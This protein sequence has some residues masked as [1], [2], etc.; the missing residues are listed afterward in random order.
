M[1]PDWKDA[2]PWA[3]YMAMDETGVWMWYEAEP[4]RV[5]R[6]GWWNEREGTRCTYAI[7]REQP[8]WKTTLEERPDEV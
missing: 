1:K 8:D 3:R 5:D 4:D 7:L 6:F 2:P